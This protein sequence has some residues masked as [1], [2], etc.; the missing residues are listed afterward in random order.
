MFLTIVHNL[1]ISIEIWHTLT[2]RIMSFGDINDLKRLEIVCKLTN[3]S[4]EI[5]SIVAGIRRGFGGGIKSAEEIDMEIANILSSLTHLCY[6]TEKL[7]HQ[8]DVSV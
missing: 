1:N 2:H 5:R 6:M 7:N 4:N 8:A 3:N